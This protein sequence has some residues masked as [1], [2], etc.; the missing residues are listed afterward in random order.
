MSCANVIWLGYT[1]PGLPGDSVCA[2]SLLHPLKKWSLRQTRGGSLCL[3]A[4]IDEI[5]GSGFG[6]LDY[7]RLK[8]YPFR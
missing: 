4:S 2:C 3:S 1:V 5:Y 8:L 7:E 6:A